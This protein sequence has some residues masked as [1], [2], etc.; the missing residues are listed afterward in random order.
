M[1]KRRLVRQNK[2]EGILNKIYDDFKASQ[3]NREKKEIKQKEFQIKKDLEKLKV[4]ERELQL[5]EDYI[6]KNDEVLKI[7]EKC[8]SNTQAQIHKKLWT[9]HN[10]PPTTSD[11]ACVL[12]HVS[13]N[14]Q[15]CGLRKTINGSITRMDCLFRNPIRVFPFLCFFFIFLSYTAFIRESKVF[16]T[17]KN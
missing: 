2:N 3:R 13:E 10:E 16:P 4:K 1:K 11:F 6:K 9:I 8:A 17:V 14:I 7:K 12:S 15:H 5:K